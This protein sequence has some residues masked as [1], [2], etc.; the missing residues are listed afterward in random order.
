MPTDE[1][2]LLI[3]FR[4]SK[5]P[6]DF[7]RTGLLDGDFDAFGDGNTFVQNAMYNVIRTLVRRDQFL[8]YVE[9]LIAENNCARCIVTGHS[10][11]GAYA[12]LTLLES[13]RRSS[14]MHLI[15]RCVG[16][17]A[18]TPF[19]RRDPKNA[20][21][22]P[23]LSEVAART[24][25]YVNEDD[26]VPRMYNLQESAST[27]F[28][29]VVG[30]FLAKRVGSGLVG[31]VFVKRLA[32]GAYASYRADYN[33]MAKQYKHF[34]RMVALDAQFVGDWQTFEMSGKSL[35]DHQPSRYVEKLELRMDGFLWPLVNRELAREQQRYSELLRKYEEMQAKNRTLQLAYFGLLC[36]LCLLV[37]ELLKRRTVVCE[38]LHLTVWRVA[39]LVYVVLSCLIPAW[40]SLA[41]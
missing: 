6:S 41:G 14:Q 20:T 2:V 13:L 24:V 26:A 32:M 12:Q 23:L 8:D 15:S 40:L 1:K 39:G 17:G 30:D 7:L 5:R 25:I 4:G 27:T 28:S 21:I 10:L 22:P 16:F 19:G 29:T 3:V 11:G 34:A 35:D 18:P 36:I 37:R 38:R 9:G 31:R 33:P